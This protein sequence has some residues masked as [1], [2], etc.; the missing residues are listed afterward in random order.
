MGLVVGSAGGKCERSLK[1]W[2]ACG[3]LGLVLGPREDDA[4]AGGLLTAGDGRQAQA[5]THCPDEHHP[6]EP[7]DSW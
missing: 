1:N 2:I 5:P 3:K 4:G 7:R 6:L